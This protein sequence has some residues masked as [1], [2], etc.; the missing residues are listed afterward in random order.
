MY[1][2]LFIQSLFLVIL[3]KRLS[4]MS[5]NGTEANKAPQKFATSPLPANIPTDIF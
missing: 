2:F 1:F 3:V 5:Q 4:A